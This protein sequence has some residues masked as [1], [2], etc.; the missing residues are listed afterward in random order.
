MDDKVFWSIWWIVF[1]L[2]TFIMNELYNFVFGVD[3]WDDEDDY[4][5]SDEWWG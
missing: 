1:A 4:L 2:L 5:D 3:E